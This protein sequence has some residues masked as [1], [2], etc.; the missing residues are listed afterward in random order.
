MASSNRSS[1]ASIIAGSIILV[2]IIVVIT[3][4]VL[5]RG[6]GENSAEPSTTPASSTSPDPD[7]EPSK[8]KDPKSPKPDT[9]SPSPSARPSP[10]PSPTL[11][12]PNYDTIRATVERAANRDRRG[13]VKHVGEV[14]IYKT[15]KGTCATRTGA[16]VNVRYTSADPS[17]FGVWYLCQR[18][19]RWFITAGPLYGE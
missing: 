6:D 19:E 8:S 11:P 10:A 5:F 14:R 3:L 1:G 4:V 17:K 15:D 12:P 2:G 16:S 13:E 9:P 18:G 7:P